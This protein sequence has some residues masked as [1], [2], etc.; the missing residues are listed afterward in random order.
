VP[1]VAIEVEN[2]GRT[3]C[4]RLIR[5][6]WPE[7]LHIVLMCRWTKV[8]QQGKNSA[9]HNLINPLGVDVVYSPIWNFPAAFCN[10]CPVTVLEWDAGHAFSKPPVAKQKSLMFHHSHPLRI[11]AIIRALSVRYRTNKT[12]SPGLARLSALKR[13]QPAGTTGPCHYVLVFNILDF[14]Q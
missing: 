10:C 4:H 3:R 12:P 13:V 8:L 11:W 14:K 7:A 1:V 2:L 6:R 9:N 5:Y